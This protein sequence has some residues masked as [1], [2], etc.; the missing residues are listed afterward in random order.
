MDP[1]VRRLDKTTQNVGTPFIQI[2]S[3][4]TTL[5]SNERLCRDAISRLETDGTDKSLLE[6]N[7]LQLVMCL[8]QHID[9]PVMN[10]TTFWQTITVHWK[11]VTS[12]S[13]KRK[14]PISKV[15]PN[16]RIKATHLLTEEA[17]SLEAYLKMQP[18]D[19]KYQDSGKAFGY[20]ASCYLYDRHPI[21]S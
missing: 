14:T 21:L 17:P 19:S 4:S 18:A 8:V 5:T 15:V 16:L 7:I 9:L 1:Q 2:R 20:V 3:R 10:R 11:A 6:D 13:V 12:P